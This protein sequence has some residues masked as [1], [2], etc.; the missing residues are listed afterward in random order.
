MWPGSYRLPHDVDTDFSEACKL[1]ENA[2]KT[3]LEKV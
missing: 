3:I 1:A 2:E